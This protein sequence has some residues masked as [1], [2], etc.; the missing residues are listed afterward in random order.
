MK[1][2]L[3]I[4][5]S[6]NLLQ[7]LTKRFEIEIKDVKIYGAES[8]RSGLQIARTESPDLI[9]LDINLPDL[10][11]YEVLR[12][13]KHPRDLKDNESPP[14]DIPVLI[15]TSHGPEER[16]RFMQAGAIGYISSPFDTRD[17]IERVKAI[18]ST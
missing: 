6:A 14:H 9:I 11:G 17:L 4:D 18:L 15:L 7:T 5:D 16:S 2:I 1:K 3:C 10:D 8:G 13:L 12:Q